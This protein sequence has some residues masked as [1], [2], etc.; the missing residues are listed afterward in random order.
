MRIKLIPAIFCALLIMFVVGTLTPLPPDQA[1]IL[2][3][4]LNKTFSEI[5][6]DKSL[7]LITMKIL[8]NNIRIALIT[9]VP[10]AGALFGF[11]ALF[12]TGLGLSAISFF[13]NES[14][15]K[16][17]F[18]VLSAPHT[19]LEIVSLSL[20]CAESLT[21]GYLF[22]KRIPVRKELGITFSIIFLS[23]SIL[24]L[25]AGLEAMLI[26]GGF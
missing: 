24:T 1:R 19:W 12:S 23:I 8:F 9:I 13:R 18:L 15:T 7:E 26:L 11:L 16:L 21:I 3:E 10:L 20:L 5:A 6:K 14:R 22:L 4:E 2:Y 17:L 25:A